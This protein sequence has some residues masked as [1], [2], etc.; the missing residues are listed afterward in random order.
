MQTDSSLGAAS[1]PVHRQITR[2]SRFLGDG[3]LDFWG[4]NSRFLGVEFV[5]FLGVEF[6]ILGGG[7]PCIDI[8]NSVVVVIQCIL[9]VSKWRRSCGSCKDDDALEPEAR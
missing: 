2:D 9:F 3:I 8:D 1:G 4:W 6:R 7:I 5:I